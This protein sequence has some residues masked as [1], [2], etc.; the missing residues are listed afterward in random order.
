MN[1]A[2]VRFLFAY[3]RWATRR[4]LNTAAA[5]AP[6]DWARPNAIGERGMG[7]ILQHA[8]GAHL[9]WRVSWQGATMRPRP[10]LDPLPTATELRALWDA[11][12]TALDAYLDSL[13]DAT[14]AGPFDVFRL[15]QAMAH[16]VNH[17]TQHRSEVAGL[18][19][20][21]GHSPGDLDMVDFIDEQ[22]AD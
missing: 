14:V 4:V 16:V 7:G 8:Y 15:W 17:G 3:D 11:E 1:V 20:G 6:E 19:T 5:I 10:E 13:D 22:S 21:L 12:W 9:R 2:D 18:M